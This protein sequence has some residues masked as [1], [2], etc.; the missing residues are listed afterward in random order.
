MAL[1]E[2]G[3]SHGPNVPPVETRGSGDYT[4]QILTSY[5]ASATAGIQA[6]AT[7]GVQA[8]SG[9]VARGLA[10]AT[11]K[12]ARGAVDA[13]LLEGI[14]TD[15]TRAGRFLGRLTVGTNGRVRILRAGAVASVVYG[16]ADPD[17]WRYSLQMGGPSASQTVWTTAS[18]TVNVRLNSDSY[19][20]WEGIAPLS[21]AV[22]SGQLAARLASSLGDEASIVV[23]RIIPIAQGSGKGAANQL[24][25]AIGGTLPG[26][27]AFP[28]SQAG[29]GG[30]GRSSAPQRDFGATKTGWDSPISGPQLY[31]HL[32]SE[33]SECCGV[34]G[35]LV[36]PA[37]AGP[38]AREAFRRLTTATL[39]PYCR[40][41]E[42]ELSRVL[43]R[44]VTITLRRLGGVDAAG[45]ARALHVL[46][47][48][49]FTPE[50]AQ[51]LLGWD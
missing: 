6:S 32:F 5:V 9:I 33:V 38:A 8:A 15:L 1:T 26:R 13:Q 47:E 21:R 2:L 30:A 11:V 35:A 10:S 39:E 7:A 19:R 14:G 36:S 4:D 34:P 18:E 42:A 24:S 3:I 51:D 12:G 45:R 50:S 16:D 29:G 41:L 23:S 27:L 40:L 46:T 37:S 22:A 17:S 43:E 48:A 28:E 20:P 44:T 31:A 49:G 25:Q